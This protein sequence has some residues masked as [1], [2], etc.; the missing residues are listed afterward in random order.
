MKLLALFAFLALPV[1]AS[2]F[3]GVYARIDRVVLEPASGTPERA[4]IWGVFSIAKITNP[5]DY[6]A[7]VRGYLYVK[8]DR[9]PEA[10]RAEWNDLKQ[11]A[12]SGEIVAFGSRGSVMH[13]RKSGDAPDNP[14]AYRTN[15]GVNHVRG[16]TDYAPVRAILDFKE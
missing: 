7:P 12:G 1:C 10:A 5:N 4:Q 15:V 14:D 8:L 13:V 3:T 6:D 9:N 16:R 11:V 2:D